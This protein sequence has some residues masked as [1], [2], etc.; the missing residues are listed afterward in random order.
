MR[1]ILSV[2]VIIAICG[3]NGGMR[4]AFQRKERV[5]E[6]PRLGAEYRFEDG[7]RRQKNPQNLWSKQERKDMENGTLH[8]KNR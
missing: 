3:C 5:Y 6:P 2:I 7:L 4:S 1:S 8:P